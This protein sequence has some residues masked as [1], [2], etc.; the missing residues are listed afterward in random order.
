MSN[1][2]PSWTSTRTYCPCIL[3]VTRPDI[4]CRSKSA[5]GLPRYLLEHAERF[6]F[7]LPGGCKRESWCL[8]LIERGGTVCSILEYLFNRYPLYPE[9]YAYLFPKYQPTRVNARSANVIQRS[10]FNVCLNSK[11]KPVI[12]ALKIIYKN[13]IKCRELETKLLRYQ[14]MKGQG[15]RMTCS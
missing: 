7:L 9:I 14:R 15:M 4:L 2:F 3:L 5:I 1:S 13:D 8:W 6:S 12:V 10:T 11:T